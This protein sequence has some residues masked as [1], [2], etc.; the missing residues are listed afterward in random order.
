MTEQ[1]VGAIY[2]SVARQSI[3]ISLTNTLTAD[4]ITDVAAGDGT[5]IATLTFCTTHIHINLTLTSVLK[6]LV[7]LVMFPIVREKTN[8]LELKQYH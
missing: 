8:F 3:D 1:V 5:I 4:T 2:A 7:L 6:K